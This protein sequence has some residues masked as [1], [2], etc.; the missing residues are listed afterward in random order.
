MNTITKTSLKGKIFFFAVFFIFLITASLFF[1]RYFSALSVSEQTQSASEISQEM[2]QEW[3]VSEE[4]RLAQTSQQNIQKRKTRAQNIDADGDTPASF[5]SNTPQRPSIKKDIPVAAQT[6]VQLSISE[7]GD[8]KIAEE[9]QT[10]QT[11][12]AS[13]EKLPKQELPEQSLTVIRIVDGDTLALSDKKT[14]RLIG[15]N[16]PEKDQPYYTEAKNILSN[17][18]FGKPVR[19]E[20][21]VS[22]TDRYGRLLRYVYVDDIFINLE[23]IQSGLAHAY[24]YPPDT[25][26]KEEFLSAE[27]TARE[28]GIGLWKKSS[29]SVSLIELHA[30]AQGSD[31]KNLN[32]EYVVLKNIGSSPLPLSHWSM[33]DAGTHIYTFPDFTLPGN[34][35]VTVFSGKG[36]NT[37]DSLYWNSKDHIWNNGSDTLYLRTETGELAIEYTYSA[38]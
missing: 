31:A 2:P 4:Y 19:L 7:R 21:D 22:D 5:R 18:T 28:Q 20:K 24:A 36:T 25:A 32:G 11:Q 17:L 23:M 35:A 14:V 12:S 29:A 38:P 13:S 10:P 26:H 6:G 1:A 15:I 3:Q 9:S 37:A 33:K 30:D 8:E 16:T 27:R 34:A